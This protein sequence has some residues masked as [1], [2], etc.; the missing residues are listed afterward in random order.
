MGNISKFINVHKILLS[1]LGVVIVSGG[2]TVGVV[3]S[4]NPEPVDDEN[5]AVVDNS[6]DTTEEE[7]EEPEVEIEEQK[8]TE[9]VV[10][11]QQSQTA[12]SS[13]DDSKRVSCL[14]KE[15]EYALRLNSTKR[16]N[17]DDEVRQAWVSLGEDRQR[18]EYGDSFKVFQ[19][20]YGL[21]LRAEFDDWKA[22]SDCAI[23]F[24]Y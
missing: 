7:N 1:V 4:Q 5:I 19:H 6:E 10:A 20:R 24:N 15:K 14:Q 18:D 12:V 11:V 16:V 21:A 13:S 2:V 17:G 8:E 22:N 9:P 3:L 23:Y